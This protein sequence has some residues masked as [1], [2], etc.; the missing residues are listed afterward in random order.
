LVQAQHRKPICGCLC[1]FDQLNAVSLG[2]E[3]GWV[4]IVLRDLFD[5]HSQM[6]RHSFGLTCQAD[7]QPIAY[8]LANSCTG[9][10]VDL[11]ILPKSWIGHEIFL[12]GLAAVEAPGFQRDNCNRSSNVPLLFF[13]S[14]AALLRALCSNESGAAHL[15]AP[16]ACGVRP[17]RPA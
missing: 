5:Q 10:A 8:F 1:K 2:A 16:E 12:V 6:L 15:T 14:H 3:C 9:N 4:G 17:L 7:T 13:F 11:N